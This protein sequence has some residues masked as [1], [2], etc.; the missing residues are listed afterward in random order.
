MGKLSRMVLTVMVLTPVGLAHADLKQT[1]EKTVTAVDHGLKKAG[2]VVAKG[3]EKGADGV[4]YGAQKTKQGVEKAATWA[5]VGPDGSNK[6][7]PAR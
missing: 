3:L 4:A 1:E 5:G 6:P 7:V 2:A